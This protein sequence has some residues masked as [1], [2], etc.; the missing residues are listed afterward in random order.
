MTS[1]INVCYINYISRFYIHQRK[2]NL[3]DALRPMRTVENILKSIEKKKR[4]YTQYNFAIIEGFALN[5]FFDLAQEFSPIEDLY[6]L[7]VS[8]PKGFF[9]LDSRLYLIEPKSNQFTLAASTEPYPNLNL[10]MPAEFIPSEIPYMINNI[11][12]LT[13][14]GK[15]TLIEQL[16]FDTI[17]NVIAFLTVFPALEI[18]ERQ[19]LFFQK[20][21]NRIG[22]NIH[23]RFVVKKNIEHLRFIRSLV[24]DIE[25]NIIVPNMIF[26]LYLRG[27]KSKIAKNLEIEKLLQKYNEEDSCDEICLKTLLTE[28]IDVNQGLSNELENINKHYK[29]TTLF[30]ETLL[31][32]SH[33]DKG[34]LTLR[35]KSCKMKQDVIMPQLD[36]YKSRLE[37]MGIKVINKIQPTKDTE[38]ITVVDIGLMAQVYANLFSN[39]LKYSNEI[40]TDEGETKKYIMIS[41]DILKDYFGQNKD[42][43]KYNFFS[44]GI[45]IKE[46]ERNLI[47]QEGFRGSNISNKPGTGH[48]LTFIKNTIEIHGGIVGYEPL[49]YGNN[50]FFILPK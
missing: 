21:A 30:L 25:H 20:Y 42:G 43:I 36:N 26:K 8:I 5:T 6:N 11:L 50:F 32:R 24:A 3:G 2:N 18:N 29:N 4:D 9:Q 48:G 38:I 40:T 39:A 16:P 1:N 41:R 45:H 22:F 12:V 49:K 34:H 15:E 46:G 31:R 19:R 44:S 23:D 27:M 14:K 7:C 17:G 10:P 33:F 13:I 28:L 37:E 35:T 47:Y